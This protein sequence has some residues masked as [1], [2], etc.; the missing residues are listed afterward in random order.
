MV[1]LKYK[2]CRHLSECHGRS[3]SAPISWTGATISD[4][5]N[6]AGRGYSPDST[7]WSSLGTC[8]SPLDSV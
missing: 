6:Y 1:T 7:T 4:G 2:G 3:M 8:V 5:L